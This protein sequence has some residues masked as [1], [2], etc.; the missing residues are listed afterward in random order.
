MLGS[1]LF[2]RSGTIPPSTIQSMARDKF[3]FLK[4]ENAK[5]A[6]TKA[7]IARAMLGVRKL[8]TS[9][10]ANTLSSTTQAPSDTSVAH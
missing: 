6:I 2:V 8:Y 10:A 3:L 7:M 1:G 4:L 5:K 9:L